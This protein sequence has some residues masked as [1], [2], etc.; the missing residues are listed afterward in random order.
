VTLAPANS[1]RWV[2]VV[3]CVTGGAEDTPYT[4]EILQ[5]LEEEGLPY[6]VENRLGDPVGVI[7]MAH[8]AAGRSVF[9]VGICS[10]EN[11][12]VLHCL[13][14]PQEKPLFVIQTCEYNL[15]KARLLGVNA[16]RLA[17]GVPF[18]EI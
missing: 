17:K 5:G 4:R 18:E 6:A 12:M 11:A 7:E 14:L 1:D 2:G 15:K 10:S 3:I 13:N 16:A 9:G 8:E